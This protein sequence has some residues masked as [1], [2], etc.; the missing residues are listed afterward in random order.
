MVG[1]CGG[2]LDGARQIV[3]CVDDSVFW[4]YLRLSKVVAEDFDGVGDEGGFDGGVNDLKAA[5]VL[6][7]GA[8]GEASA[9]VVVPSFA[10][11]HLGVN[12]D[13]TTD[14]GDVRGVEVEGA[15]E[16]LSGGHGG[17]DGGL[18]E[19][20]ERELGLG[21]ELVHRNVGNVADTPGRIERK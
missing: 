6:E 16:V 18:A 14:R 13:R 2:V 21:K 19:E 15:V 8:N 9:A 7:G 3:E 12:D 5:V 11:T 1:G 17:G 4:S 10:G 20:V